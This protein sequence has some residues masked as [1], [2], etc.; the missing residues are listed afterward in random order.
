MNIK[1]QANACFKLKLIRVQKRYIVDERL[2][3]IRKE[4]GHG[5]ALYPA[6]DE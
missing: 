2:R 3:W 4:Y 6:A 1:V 5:A